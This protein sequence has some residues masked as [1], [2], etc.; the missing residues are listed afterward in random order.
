MTAQQFKGDS[1]QTQL[2]LGIN[3][4][5]ATMTVDDASSLPTANFTIVLGR[6]TV[7]EE[8]VFVTSRTAT[9]LSGC[10]RGY[11]DTTQAAH[12]ADTTVDHCVTAKWF[13]AMD[14]FLNAGVRALTPAGVITAFA[15]PIAPPLHVMCD[16]AA[17][18]GTNPAYA[19]LYAVIGTTYGGTPTAFLVPNLKGKVIVMRDSSQVEFDAL[20]EGAAWGEKSHTLSAAE[21]GVHAHP[22]V[23]NEPNAGQGHDHGNGQHKHSIDHGHGGSANGAAIEDHGHGFSTGDAGGHAHAW[24]VDPSFNFL[25]AK[26]N[27][28]GGAAPITQPGAYLEQRN[29]TAGVGNHN[30]G[31]TVGSKTGGGTHAHTV[32]VPATVG[33]ETNQ[34][35]NSVNRG[36]SGTTVT[37]NPNTGAGQPH[38]N[39]QPYL[40]LNYIIRL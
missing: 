13:Q 24:D 20:G 3:A 1:L 11:D 12:A 28:A 27:A 14:D 33:L 29:Q 34:I 5:D 18:D 21:V 36:V 26:N 19:P 15:G 7:T 16:G 31:G 25:G 32:T 37:V 40:V 30:H 22:A 8:K 23:V 10:T 6:G 35:G 39:L 2:T 38:N 17:Y 4:T 9:V